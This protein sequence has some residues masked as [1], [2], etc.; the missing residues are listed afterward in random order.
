MAKLTDYSFSGM[1]YADME[2]SRQNDTNAWTR[3]YEYS[4]VEYLYI[5]TTNT[6]YTVLTQKAV[7]VDVS[8]SPSGTVVV[9]TVFEDGTLDVFYSEDPANGAP[10]DRFN[11]DLS[12]VGNAEECAV[13]VTESI[14]TATLTVA[15]RVGDEIVYGFAYID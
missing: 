3:V 15:A 14:G 7:D 10:L 8:T 2:F 13:V 5:F 11:I 12:S 1:L 6:N 9:C 4:N